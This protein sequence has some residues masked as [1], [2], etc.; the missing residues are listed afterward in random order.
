M[1]NRPLSLLAVLIALAASLG[2]QEKTQV[3]QGAHIIPITG[4]PIPQGVLVVTGGKIIAVGPAGQVA[5]PAGAE[6]HDVTGKVLM[7]GLVD[8][9]SHVGA[10]SG[11]DGSGPLHPDAR[12]L[13][14]IDVR[15]SSLQKA[16]A[17]GIK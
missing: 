13:D 16:Q 3:F 2:A 4:D 8:S 9:H 15:D 11:G 6:I 7:P 14:S 17:G 5:I 10:G 1:P 12:V